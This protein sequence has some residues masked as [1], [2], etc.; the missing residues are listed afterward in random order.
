MRIPKPSEVLNEAVKKD[1]RP[2]P[3]VLRDKEKQVIK[4]IKSAERAAEATA[5][6]MMNPTPETVREAVR[7]AVAT[8]QA[9]DRF[10]VAISEEAL[11]DLGRVLIGTPHETKIISERFA[12]ELLGQILQ[13]EKPEG[14]SL[15]EWASPQGQLARALAA[16]IKASKGRYL[17]EERAKPLPADLKGLMALGGF[18]PEILDSAR[19]AQSKSFEMDLPAVINGSNKFFAGHEYAVTLDD[20]IV[21]SEIPEAQ[22]SIVWWAHELYH[23][24]QYTKWSVAGFALRYV[25]QWDSVEAEAKKKASE[26]AERINKRLAEDQEGQIFS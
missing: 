4:D 25:T 18:P 20:L 19:I 3:Q 24:Y 16:A 23:V 21:F 14:A 6:A 5:R 8:S 12:A 10:V 7:Q 15:E 17:D 26:I 11:G 9:P 2:K 22:S 1:P 13:G